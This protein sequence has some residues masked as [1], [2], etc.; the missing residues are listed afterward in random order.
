LAPGEQTGPQEVPGGGPS[1]LRRVVA[2]LLCAL[3]VLLVPVA[4]VSVWARNQLLDTD[5]YLRTVGPVI[6]EP[7]VQQALA[8]AAAGAVMDRIDISSRLG[9][10]TPA[11]LRPIALGA[12]AQLEP[13][14]ERIALR[15][16]GADLTRE[17]WVTANRLAH[18]QL[19]RVLA[20][21]SR[22]LPTLRD[23][24]VVDLSGVSGVVAQRLVDSGVPVDVER[25]ESLP[26]V[27]V[28]GEVLAQVTDGVRLLDRVADVLPWVILAL[29][30]AVVALVPRRSWRYVALSAVLGGRAAGAARDRAWPVPRG[31]AG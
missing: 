30:A 21:G 17:G 8:S 25:L 22:L 27:V 10:D 9:P 7:A 24:I 28:G 1:R 2:G 14:V 20:G 12:V 4:A 26:V 3:I 16:V 31:V 6:E 23:G 11:I 18:T 19:V 13:Y 5:A 15:V 29:L